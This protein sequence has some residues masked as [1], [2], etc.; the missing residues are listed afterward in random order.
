MKEAIK[1]SPIE[2]VSNTEVI[3]GIFRQFHEGLTKGITNKN[4]FQALVPEIITPNLV[5]LY[6]NISQG[7]AL[8]EITDYVE[9][10]IPLIDV[11]DMREEIHNGKIV[12]V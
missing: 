6:G 12:K 7:Q 3:K 5:A 4:R 11:P 9:S 10:L 1:V 2:M 8:N